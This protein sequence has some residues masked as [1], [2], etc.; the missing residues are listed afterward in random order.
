MKMINCIPSLTV[1]LR[2]HASQDMTNIKL[3]CAFA[4]VVM[5]QLAVSMVRSGWQAC[6]QSDIITEVSALQLDQ[7]GMHD[8]TWR[9]GYLR[10]VETPT[11]KSSSSRKF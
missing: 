7:V 2:P 8:P 6:L 3:A 4:S 10:Q 1:R 11:E 5:L 9:L